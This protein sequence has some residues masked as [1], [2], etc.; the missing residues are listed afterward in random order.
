MRGRAPL[1]GRPDA[2]FSTRGQITKLAADGNRVAVVTRK[3]KAFCGR[4]VVWT[5][6]GRKSTSFEAG[7][8]G[9][10][11]CKSTCVGEL[12][13]GGGQ[14]AWITYGGGNSLEFS[15]HAAKLSGGA[16]KEIDD[17]ANGA[18][19]GEDPEG[20]WLGQ[21]LGGGPLL[22][23]NKWR[24]VCSHHDPQ[25]DYCD[26]WDLAGKKLVRIASGRPVVVKRG[27]GACRLAAVGGGRVV[28]AGSVPWWAKG[29]SGCLDAAPS[30]GAVT[31]LAPRGSQVA[32]VAAVNENPPRAI[33]LSRTRLAL[34]RTFTLELYDPATGAKA[35]SLPLGPAAALQLAGVNSKLALLRGPRRLVLVRLSDGE[36]ISVP[37]RPGAATSLVGARL[38]E[39]GLF[40]AYNTPRAAAKGRIVFE[41]TAKLVARF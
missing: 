7:G 6:P 19:A 26:R 33:A 38:I 34:L 12:A 40:Y 15:V 35:K 13:V 30:A 37:L 20:G 5:A 27:A 8:C 36:L 4:V 17:A 39:A 14:V 3:I 32:T 24:V 31:V 9:S 22:V 41:P 10:L 18:G 25:Y 28:V 11:L 16:A 1:P 29:L 21:L 2:V 23:Y